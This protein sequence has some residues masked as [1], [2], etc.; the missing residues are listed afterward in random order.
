MMLTVH[1]QFLSFKVA[2]CS[3]IDNTDVGGTFVKN[4]EIQAIAITVNT[5]INTN[6]ARH[7][8][9]FPSTRPSGTPST[10]D[11]LIPMKMIPIA[12]ARKCGSTTLEASVTDSAIINEPL[13]AQITLENISI[14]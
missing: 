5:A 11:P 3:F 2:S 4:N 1:L 13:A 8:Y 12:R 9:A 14:P 7:P 10:S 6:G